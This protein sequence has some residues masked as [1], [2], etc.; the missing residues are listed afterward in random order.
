LAIREITIRGMDIGCGRLT[1]W[2]LHCPI[3]HRLQSFLA[4]KTAHRWRGA[5]YGFVKI[6]RNKVRV[7]KVVLDTGEIETLLTNLAGDFDFKA[8]YFI[9]WG[10][11]I[12]FDVLKNTLEIENF[13]G[14]TETAVRQDFHI[15]IISSNMLAASFLEAQEIA[16]KQRNNC[17]N[18]YEYKINIAQAAS[19][20]RDY[21]PMAIL[22]N[23]PLRQTMLLN[24]MTEIIASAVI[25]IRPN[26]KVQRKRNNRRSK[27]HHNRK[28]NL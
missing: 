20:V 5:Q 19:A 16:D 1:A 22:S 8:L 12:R 17:G 14:R 23:D 28:P 18:K 15:H 13:S 11:E 21:L 10:I 26:R 25:P 2:K 9:R 3:I 7:I 27:F 24:K 6:G 4:A